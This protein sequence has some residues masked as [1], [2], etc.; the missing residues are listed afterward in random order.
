MI[1]ISICWR[2]KS[3]RARNRCCCAM[4]ETLLNS[5]K[6]MIIFLRAAGYE[7]E[8]MS[9]LCDY[10]ETESLPVYEMDKVIH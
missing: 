9:G 8:F 10:L 4:Q 5:L 2:T 1:I 3:Q 7:F 6:N